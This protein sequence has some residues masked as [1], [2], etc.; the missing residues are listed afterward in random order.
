MKVNLNNLRKQA[1]FSY[2]RLAKKLNDAKSDHNDEMG[3]I[4]IHPDDIQQDMD[5]LRQ[6]LFGLACTYVEGSEDF[7]D[8]SEEVEPIAWFNPEEETEEIK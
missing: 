7:K 5:N 4:L 8:V 2:D 1:L 3:N 6:Q